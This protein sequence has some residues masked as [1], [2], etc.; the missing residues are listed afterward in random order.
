MGEEDIDFSYSLFNALLN[1]GI[2][3]LCDMDMEIMRDLWVRG[4]RRLSKYVE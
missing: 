4:L 1:P 2:K 3:Q